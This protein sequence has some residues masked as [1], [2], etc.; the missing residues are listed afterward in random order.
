MPRRR[1]QRRRITTRRANLAVACVAIVLA[2]LAAGSVWLLDRV[3]RPATGAIGGPF[4]LT[5][6]D[7]HVVTQRD[8]RGRYLL[9]YFGYTSCPDVCPTTLSAIAD[10]VGILGA[11][12]DRLRAVFVTVDP[13]RDTAHVVAAYVRHFGGRIIGLSGTPEQITAMERAYHV[14]SVVYPNE[15]DPG[16]YSVGHTAV[17]FLVGPDGRYLRAFAPMESGPDLARKLAAYLA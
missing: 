13:H 8:F 1:A 5:Q 7:G 17:L 14:T 12:A 6:A 9:L 15:R 10:A 4:A 16:Q 3:G 11:R 2:V